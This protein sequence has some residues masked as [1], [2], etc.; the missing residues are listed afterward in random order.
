MS[1]IDDVIAQLESGRYSDNPQNLIADVD[2]MVAAL[3]LLQ[4]GNPSPQ[5]AN[6][7][8]AGPASGAAALPAFR[9]L[10]A[11]D[12]PPLPSF[13]MNA[14]VLDQSGIASG[15]VTPINFGNTDWNIGSGVIAATSYQNKE[16]GT[17]RWTL[18]AQVTFNAANI[19]RTQAAFF[20]NGIISPKRWALWQN[21]PAITADLAYGFSQD[22][23]LAF[24]DIVTV[25]GAATN[26]GTFTFENSAGFGCSFSGNR[27]L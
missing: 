1:A 21:M 24:N 25:Q 12:L 26:G 6:T 7:V 20:I 8:Y 15:T 27:Q 11:A 5:S 14:G 16:P 13:S 10:V 22:L 18:K 23:E 3:R 2:T 19:T 9:A 4:A 17:T